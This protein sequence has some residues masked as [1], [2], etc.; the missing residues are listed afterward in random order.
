MDT[1][2]DAAIKMDHG[3][4][5]SAVTNLRPYFS[6]GGKLL[7]YHGW[8]DSQ[9]P[10][11]NSVEYFNHVV[12]ATGRTSIGKSPGLAPPKIFSTYTGI[13]G[14]VSRRPAP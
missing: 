10:A 7:I 9:V 12:Q 14:N 8:A 13:R 3:V 2:V 6:R 11:L 5:D 4:L 1:D